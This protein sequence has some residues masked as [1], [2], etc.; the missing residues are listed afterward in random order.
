MF[1]AMVSAN[2]RI[3]RH[4]EMDMSLPHG[5]QTEAKKEEKESALSKVMDAADVAVAGADLASGAVRAIGH[6]ALPLRA[7]P[8]ATPAAF[9]TGGVL[10]DPATF[11]TGDGEAAASAAEAVVDSAGL[12]EAAGDAIGAVA[13]GVGAVAGA[14]GEIVGGIISA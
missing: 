8:L 4:E 5:P 13:E 11:T 14:I 10:A 9:T 1:D 3:S 2:W 12:L 7:V 6:A